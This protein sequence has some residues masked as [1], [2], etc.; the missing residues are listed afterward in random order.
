MDN[1]LALEESLHTSQQK[2]SCCWPRNRNSD[3]RK[4]IYEGEAGCFLGRQSTVPALEWAE[5]GKQDIFRI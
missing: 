2:I 3:S 1:H 5:E 4:G